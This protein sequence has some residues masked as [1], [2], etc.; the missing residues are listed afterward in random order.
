MGVEFL[1][2]DAGSYLASLEDSVDFYNDFVVSFLKSAVF[3]IVVGLIATYQGYTCTPTTEGVSAAT[4]STVVTSSVCILV[5]D[6]VITA[7]WGV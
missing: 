5:S 4:T 6:Y 3:G 7:L 1:G 2:L